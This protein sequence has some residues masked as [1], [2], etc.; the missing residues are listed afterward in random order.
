MIELDQTTYRFYR[1]DRLNLVLERY[2]GQNWKFVGYYP[3]YLSLAYTLANTLTGKSSETGNA[4]D[5]LAATISHQQ[6]ALAA[7]VLQ[8]DNILNRTVAVG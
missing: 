7:I 6:E 3:D 2:N 8:L 4:H 1:Y 5:L